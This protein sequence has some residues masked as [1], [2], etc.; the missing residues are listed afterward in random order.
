MLVNTLPVNT[1]ACNHVWMTERNSD[2]DM[3]CEHFRLG[4][5]TEAEAPEHLR[6][7]LLGCGAE[8]KHDNRNNKG[9]Q[10][11]QSL[12][13]QIHPPLQELTRG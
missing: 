12:R 13:D 5:R 11:R 10:R 9:F 2:V 6:E 7:R 1:E 8:E 3:R 4:C